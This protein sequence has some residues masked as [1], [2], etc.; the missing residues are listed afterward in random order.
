MGS[1]QVLLLF[2]FCTRLTFGQKLDNMRI[3]SGKVAHITAMITL[4]LLG[5][6]QNSRDRVVDQSPQSPHP[7]SVSVLA[8]QNKQRSAVL[9]YIYQNAEKTNLCEGELDRSASEQ[10]SSVYP[11][12]QNRYLVQILCFMGAYQGNYRYFLYEKQ[13]DSVS[14]QPLSLE[15]YEPD[16]AGKITKTLENNVG[17]SPDYNAGQKT[18]S[19]ITK[20][21]GLDD[22]GSL[23]K[24]QWDRDR[25]KVVEYRVK[26]RCDGKYI[27]PEKY[28][29]VYP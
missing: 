2:Y 1:I 12:A 27:E 19:M 3:F 11:L 25:F 16:D 13:A 26:D 9:P 28:I 7:S 18:L 22:C 15:R 23:A 29:Q 10:F 21:R 5:C 17:G 24:Y 4:T 6:S 20:Y 14:V 8:E